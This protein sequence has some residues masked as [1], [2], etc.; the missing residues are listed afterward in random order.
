MGRLLSAFFGTLRRN[1]VLFISIV[2]ILAGGSWLRGEWKGVQH[3]AAALPS[4]ER[5]RKDV[6]GYVAI[7]TDTGV[8]QAR[9]LAGA[10][11]Q[12]VNARIRTVDSEIGLLEAGQAR[13]GMV[14]TVLGTDTTV[15]QALAQAAKTGVALELLRQERSYL[16]VLRA[17]A[18]TM[19]D[20]ESLREELAR[21][22]GVHVKAYAAWQD[23]CRARDR[24]RAQ[25]GLRTM[26]PRTDAR[27][28]LLALDGQVA[29]LLAAN[30]AASADYVAQAAQLQRLPAPSAPPPFRIER[31]RL[32]VILAPLDERLREARDLAAGNY[33]WRVYLQTAPLLPAAFGVL[34]GWWLVPAAVRAFFYYVLAP[35]AARRPPVVIGAAGR[36][37]PGPHLRDPGSGRPVSAVSQA[38]TLEP[39]HELLVRPEYCQS[40]PAG[41]AVATT[42]LFDWRHWLTSVAAHLWMLKRLRA[43]E[44]AVIVVSS[45]ADPLDEVALLELAAGE[46]FVLQPRALAGIMYGSGR[47]PRIRSHWRLG[48]LHAWLTLQ[49]RYLSFEGPAVLVVRGCRGVRLEH[50]TAGRTV[51]Q[52]ATLGFSTGTDYATVRAEPFIP[53]LTGR[54]ALLHDRFTG[55]HAWYLYEEVPRRRRPGEPGHNPLE[56]L[57]DAGLKAF[58]I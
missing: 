26:I 1:V 20:R 17:H 45:G 40:M 7:M 58:G 14:S 22:R 2:C 38:L 34:A 5:A 41:T 16:T 47:K 32:A 30:Q 23:A 57:V 54:Q 9:R 13:A 35:L 18:S 36:R 51:S 42:W 55:P 46:A 37:R 6:D 8:R 31:A 15:A 4:L 3:T 56:V 48:T 52:D 21:L 33:L 39:G 44:A 25:E 11:L 24:F 53:Y 50:A 12:Q 19:A 49:L 27:R 43:A 28:K 10:G 29:A